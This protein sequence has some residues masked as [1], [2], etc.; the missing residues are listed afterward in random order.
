MALVFEVK[1]TPSSGRLG[2]SIDKSGTLKCS[3]TEPA[4][5]GLA[6]KQLIA[7][8]SKA[9]KISKESI[10]ILLGDTNRKK[11]I[12]INAEITY[13]QLLHLLQVSKQQSLF[14]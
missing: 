5:K 12:K 13:E 9:L 1:V 6:N 10:I 11:H 3:L 14:D 7:L 4:E 8:L 2:W